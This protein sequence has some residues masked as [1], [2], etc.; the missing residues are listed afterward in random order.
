MNTLGVCVSRCRK[1]CLPHWSFVC[2]LLAIIQ[3]VETSSL[4]PLHLSL[5]LSLSLCWSWLKW[6][7]WVG[8]KMK[9]G[10]I[11]CCWLLSV[12]VV[13]SVGGGDEQGAAQWL[14][15]GEEQSGHGFS[16]SIHRPE[17]QGQTAAGDDT[18]YGKSSFATITSI[19][20][21]ELFFKVKNHFLK[22]WKRSSQ[23]SWH[24]ISPLK[25]S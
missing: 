4:T 11:C 5:S 16:T 19:A 18:H 10:A 20:H 17:T 24:S 25:N 21:R 8:L 6:P 23:K 9:L 15:G 22:F 13:W 14:A 2:C 3:S 7:F 1:L 12:V